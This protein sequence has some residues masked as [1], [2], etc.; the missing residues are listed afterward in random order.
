MNPPKAPQETRRRA[1]GRIQ[2]PSPAAGS[3]VPT[4]F[5][6]CRGWAR[7]CAGAARCGRA[8]WCWTARRRA[9]PGPEPNFGNCRRRSP[10]DGCI[11]SRPRGC[12]TASGVG[13]GSRKT[14][15]RGLNV[16]RGGENRLKGWKHGV[17]S[18]KAGGLTQLWDLAGVSPRQV[19]LAQARYPTHASPRSPR[20]WCP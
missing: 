20:Q 2:P 18:T 9:G 10:C 6:G 12:D 1:A 16:E 8:A 3:P 17:Y 5:A 13:T 15:T 11:Y 19:G 14:K 4:Y 7:G